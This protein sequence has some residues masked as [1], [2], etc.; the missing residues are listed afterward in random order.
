MA[1]VNT[2][3]LYKIGTILGSENVPQDYSKII[4]PITKQL[5][6]VDKQMRKVKKA[7]RKRLEKL[8]K[9]TKEIINKQETIDA[10]GV[11]KN[12]SNLI[13]DYSI[14][15]KNNYA[16]AAGVTARLEGQSN[17]PQ[18]TEAVETM[19][20]VDKGVIKMKENLN[21]VVAL[22]NTIKQTI[23]T[24]SVSEANTDEQNINLNNI[25]QGNFYEGDEGEGM[26]VRRE[27]NKLFF[28]VETRDGSEE[29]TADQLYKHIG[30]AYN[31]DLEKSLKLMESDT[32]TIANTDGNTKQIKGANFIQKNI[33]SDVRA[34]INEKLKNNPRAVVDYMYKKIDGNDPLIDLYMAY[35]YGIKKYEEDGVTLTQDFKNL[36]EPPT[37]VAFG[38]KIGD[39]DT[40]DVSDAEIEE[41]IKKVIASQDPEETDIEGLREYYKNPD[42]RFAIVNEIRGERVTD[43]TVDYQWLYEKFKDLEADDDESVNLKEFL[44]RSQVDNLEKQYNTQYNSTVAQLEANAGTSR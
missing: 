35:R 33:E 31:D 36:I 43:D 4:D 17:D 41:H 26:K 12:L 22:T 21:T 7:K 5:T 11:P 44:I 24:N 38:N 27:G 16:Y 40:S 1:T 29:V 19:N 20:Q 28:T 9:R 34:T 18:Y 15:Q 10:F 13:K 2:N 42:N 3:L 32:R 14:E 25:V 8:N 23:N 37:D 6:Q 30:T 39:P